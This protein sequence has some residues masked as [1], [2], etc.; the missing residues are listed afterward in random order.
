MSIENGDT[1]KCDWKQDKST[2]TV[3]LVDHP[4]IKVESEYFFE[5]E[6]L[7]YYEIIEHFGDGEANLEFDRALPTS[8]FPSQYRRLNYFIMMSGHWDG[9]KDLENY[10]DG[11]ECKACNRCTR[12][13]ND[14]IIK[15]SSKI[16]NTD[17]LSIRNSNILILSERLSKLLEP[18]N[19]N[20]YQL[21]EVELLHPSKTKYLELIWNEKSSE[22]IN[23][24][25]IDKEIGH[26]YGWRC[27]ACGNASISYQ[28]E[29]S[30][31]HFVPESRLKE[32]KPDLFRLNRGDLCVSSKLFSEI[33]SKIKLRKIVGEQLG[34]VGDENILNDEG[35]EI[36][37]FDI[38]KRKLP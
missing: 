25:A 26:F 9:L 7:I 31:K 29:R 18:F 23:S 8:L 19:N 3:W 33:K 6:D 24:V 14:K 22:I 4:H 34:V 28:D 15:V 13:R 37:V 30:M 27:N 36:K 21:R 16:K 32:N 20:L 10:F 2:Y 1:Y 35:F 17:V 11:G 12:K 38:K 5:C